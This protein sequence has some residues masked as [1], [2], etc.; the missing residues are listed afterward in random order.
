M[1]GFFFIN[2]KR[3]LLYLNF[4][5]ITMT[6]IAQLLLFQASGYVRMEM[7]KE[8][9]QMKAKEA[10]DRMRKPGK[11]V[12][13]AV[14]K[15]SEKHKSRYMWKWALAIYIMAWSFTCASIV[16]FFMI[17]NDDQMCQTALIF[18]FAI[19]RTIYIILSVI[20]APV[21]L[22]IEVLLNKIPIFLI[23]IFFPLLFLALYLGWIAMQSFLM[24]ET[25]YGQ[26]LAIWPYN[27][28][29]SMNQTE[30]YNWTF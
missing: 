3:S 12:K 4:W 26:N 30:F 25:V 7:A 2:V 20:T 16:S 23:H 11:K 19:W 27:P 18:G 17:V 28:S 10:E 29:H 13:T 1:V 5:A 24:R 15:V 14:K 9:E 21:I 22:L 6:F 8:R